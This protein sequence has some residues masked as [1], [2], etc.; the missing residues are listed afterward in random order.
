MSD[1]VR[2]LSDILGAAD[3]LT[4]DE[5]FIALKQHLEGKDEYSTLDETIEKE[6]TFFPVCS[7]QPVYSLVFMPSFSPLKASLTKPR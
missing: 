5:M 4:K 2:K 1:S 6:F 3:E 7:P